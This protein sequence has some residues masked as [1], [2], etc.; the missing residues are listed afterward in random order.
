MNVKIQGGGG[1][2]YANSGSA[3]GV[4]SYLRHEDAK[5]QEQGEQV[6][7]F[8]DN[9]GAAVSSKEVTENIDK[10]KGQLHKEDAKFFVITVSPSQDEIKQMGKN[11]EE[12]TQA[13]KD[14]INNDLMLN[15]AENFNKDLRQDDI[16]YYGK[17]HHTRGTKDGD[18]MHAHIIVSRKDRTNTK[19]LSPQTNHKATK[20]GAVKGG[21]NR[22]NFFQKA[23]QSFDK[24]F[25]QTRNFRESY[26]YRNAMKNGTIKEKENVINKVVMQEKQQLQ[27]QAQKKLQEKQQLQQ[28][29]QQK[30]QQ[31]SRGMRI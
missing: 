2:V 3:F 9:K 18:Q 12:Q 23:E 8:F 7:P 26:E 28:L 4:V 22:S 11:K 14:Y 20:K 24:K 30:Q 27:Q 19:K 15:Y 17:I 13:F 31:R 10:N 25:N 5:L 6:Q 16:L 1:G 21:F 29:Q